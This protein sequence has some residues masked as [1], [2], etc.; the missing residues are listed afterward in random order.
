MGALRTLLVPGTTHFP[1][2]DT[3]RRVI[4]VRARACVYIPAELSY[5]NVTELLCGRQHSVT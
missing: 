4:R 1:R 2:Y 5:V 3:K